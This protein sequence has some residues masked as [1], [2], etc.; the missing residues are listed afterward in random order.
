[1]YLIIHNLTCEYGTSMKFS[2][3]VLLQWHYL[4]MQFN[5]NG[6]STLGVITRQTWKS[7]TAIRHLL[8]EPVTNK[9]RIAVAGCRD[10]AH[11]VLLL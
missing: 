6:L 11:R 1:M 4:L 2:N 7:G 10:D 3:C 8:T 5:D 9:V